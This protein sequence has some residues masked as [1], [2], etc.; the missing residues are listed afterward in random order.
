MPPPSLIVH[1]LLTGMLPAMALA[2]VVMAAVLL[3]RGSDHGVLASA[4]GLIAGA[5]LGWWL[6]ESL[7]L[8]SSDSAWNRLPAAALAA[9]WVGRLARPADLRANS[10]GLLRAATALGIAWFVIPAEVRKETDWLAPLFAALIFAQ[11]TI[12]ERVAAEPPGGSVPLCLAIVF[13]AV[14]G[15]L[16]HA[17]CARLMNSAIV[18]AA[19]LGGI[20]VVARF[21]RA[22]AGAQSPRLRS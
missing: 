15:V 17:N 20:A 1:T 12:L 18:L 5:A 9:V 21:W 10:G 16:I 13:L 6:N 19:A 14:A 3:V 7:V 11:W 4:L 2:A 22:D 8:I